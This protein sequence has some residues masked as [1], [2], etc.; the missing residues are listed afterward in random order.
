MST[1]ALGPAGPLD[2]LLGGLTPRRESHGRGRVRPPPRPL[3]LP[4]RRSRRCQY[5]PTATAQILWELLSYGLR[6]L[7]A[8]HRLPPPSWMPLATLLNCSSLIPSR[9]I[10]MSI[11]SDNSRLSRRATPQCVTSPSTGG[12][13]ASQRFVVLPFSQ[14][15]AFTAGYGLVRLSVSSPGTSGSVLLAPGYA[16]VPRTEWLRRYRD[17]VLPKGAHFW[18]KGDDGLWWLGK[19]SASTTEDRVYLVRFLDDPGTIK[20][21]LSPAHYTPQRGPCEVLSACRFT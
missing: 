10:H 13:P 17:T 14:P 2:H 4:P 21:P 20:L 8:T 12:R 3:L 19:I 15:I 18:Y 6:P 5:R 1:M 9:V 7:L 16:C 11:G